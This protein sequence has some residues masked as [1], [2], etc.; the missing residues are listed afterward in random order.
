[1]LKCAIYFVSSFILLVCLFIVSLPALADMRNVPIAE[2]I[3]QANNGNP[4]ARDELGLRYCFGIDVDKDY[5]QAAK[6]YLSA[7]EQGYAKAQNEIGG[8]YEKGI[9]VH[10]YC[11]Y[12]VINLPAYRLRW[13]ITGRSNRFNLFQMG[14]SF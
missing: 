14:I 6:W 11:G 5:V 2:L 4:E 12:G 10:N 7:A 13:S 8:F 9:G 3:L 1:M